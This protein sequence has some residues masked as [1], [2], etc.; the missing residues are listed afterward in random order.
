MF[1]KLCMSFKQGFIYEKIGYPRT[2]A[3]RACYIVHE[4]NEASTA[5]SPRSEKN[6]VCDSSN[7]RK[8]GF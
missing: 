7:V 3:L 4:K 6:V 1:G 5:A 8:Y 2:R